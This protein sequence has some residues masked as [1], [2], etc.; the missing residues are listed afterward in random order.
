MF[1]TNTTNFPKK[2]GASPHTTDQVLDFLD[3]EFNGKVLSFRADKPRADGHMRRGREWSPRSPDLSVL[4]F[5]LFPEM[6]KKVFSHPRPRTLFE[7]EEKIKVAY[8]EIDHD[9]I[10]DA[11]RNVPVRAQKCCDALG[12]HFEC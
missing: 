9:I 1:F 2:D 6:K 10:Q 4:D 8:D 3:D 12:G 11:F 7:L 5:Y